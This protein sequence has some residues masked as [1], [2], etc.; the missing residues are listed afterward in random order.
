MHNTRRDGSSGNLPENETIVTRKRISGVL[1]TCSL[2]VLEHRRDIFY[3]FS[4]MVHNTKPIGHQVI[5][6]LSILTG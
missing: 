1:D 3:P 6:T 2:R 5:S 4:L